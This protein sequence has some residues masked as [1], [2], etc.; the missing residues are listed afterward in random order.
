MKDNS[1]RP[2][3]NTAPPA[4]PSLQSAFTLVELAIVLV[5]IGLIVGGILGGTDLIKSAEARKMMRQMEEINSALQTF[6]LKY[7]CVP[8]DCVAASAFGLGTSGNGD[9]LRS[10][11][12]CGRLASRCSSIRRR[13]IAGCIG[14]IG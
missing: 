4:K 14:I 10:W 13:V 11:F 9:G 1:M 6:R 5:I 2:H 8:G 12:A 7:N 3:F